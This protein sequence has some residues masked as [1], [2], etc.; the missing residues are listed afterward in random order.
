MHSVHSQSNKA[1]LERVEIKSESKEENK[2]KEMHVSEFG[3]NLPEKKFSAGAIQATVWRNEVKTKTGEDA[4]FQT[5]SLQRS[6]KDK[7]GKWQTSSTLRAADLP[8]A[9]LVL[10][11]A[12]EHIA[13][14][15]TD[16]NN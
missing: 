9:I 1:P 3:K 11:K 8:K 5:V 14:R 4:E 13:L 12:Y 6:Y 10:Q 15:D 16:E 2:M 7:D